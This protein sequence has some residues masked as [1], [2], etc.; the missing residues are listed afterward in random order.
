MYRMLAEALTGDSEK[1]TTIFFYIAY[2]LSGIELEK[3]EAL[4]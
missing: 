4:H 1:S 2:L 3:E